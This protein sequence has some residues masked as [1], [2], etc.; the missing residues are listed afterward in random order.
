VE[1]GLYRICQ[2]A[3]ANIARHAGAGR[4]TVRLVTTP[5]RVE[6]TV[7]DDGWGFD[8]EQIPEGRYGLV[9]MSERARMLGGS[10]NVH[11]SPGAGTRVEVTVP[12]EKL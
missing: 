3:L 11:S 6:L 4:V 7:E 1:V 2:E 12:L 10:L 5:E 8:P 9:G